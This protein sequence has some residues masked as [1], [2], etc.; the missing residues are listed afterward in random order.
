MWFELKG[1]ERITQRC[2]TDGCFGQ[3]T[4]RLEHEGVGSNHCSGCREKI[5]AFLART[6][7]DKIDSE[8]VTFVPDATITNA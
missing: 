2:A 1:D 3:P 4:W 8:C 5:T 6:A 7:L